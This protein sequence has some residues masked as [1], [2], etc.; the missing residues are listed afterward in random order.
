MARTVYAVDCLEFRSRIE[1]RLPDV[2]L[3]RCC[4]VQ[5]IQW[6][7][8][9]TERDDND[10]RGRIYPRPPAMI[11][12]RMIQIYERFFRVLH[13]EISLRTGHGAVQADEGD[14]VILERDYNKLHVGGP[15]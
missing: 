7:L 12:I 14:A 8:S 6:L 13:E 1:L 9:A 3:A 5:S 15:G 2:G 11:D 4:Q 10:S